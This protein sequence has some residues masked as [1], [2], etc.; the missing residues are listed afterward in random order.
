MKIA[1]GAAE[2]F[3]KNPPADVRAVLLYG[4]DAGLVRE[5]AEALVKRVADDP[6]DPFRVAEF[7]AASLRDDPARLADEAQALSLTG[8][9]RAVR[10][11]EA[12]EALADPFESFLDGA[13]GEA[14]V[15]VESGN[16]G[17]RSKLR[18]LF[19]S[20]RHAAAVPCYAD[21][22]RALQSVIRD[23]LGR[24]AIRVSPDAMAYLLVNLGGDRMVSRTELDKLA[25]YVG[26][27]NE[28]S[29]AD[30][31]A[32]VGDSAAMTL[33]DLAFAVGA[34]DL[35]G[36][37]RAVGRAFREG[38]APVSVLRACARHVQRLHL[39]AGMVAEGR[40]PEAAVK[41]L[42][43]PVFFKQESAFLAQLR[44]WPAV[45]LGEALARLTEAELACKSTGMPAETVCAHALTRLC[46]E[47][48]A[49]GGR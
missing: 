20:A 2:T 36:L 11:R 43:P 34:G 38:A 42:R 32:V 19:E 35:A 1:A 14:L 4:P 3:V 24:R 8:G 10:V 25:L 21:D 37:D 44:R 16:L 31:A 26:D 12:G 15:I 46:A 17:P 29:L 39:A 45:A 48:R 13:V 49:R 33:D 18:K 28:A 41:A 5:R 40:P 30:A 22:G 27:G 9:R 23:A 6:A 47:A 7:A